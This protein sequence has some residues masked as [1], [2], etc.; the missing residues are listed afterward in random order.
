MIIP[1]GGGGKIRQWDFIITGNSLNT[2]STSFVDM[3]D[4][5]LTLTTLVNSKIYA[6]FAGTVNHN[7]V[8][9]KYIDFKLIIDGS[10]MP[11][12]GGNSHFRYE[13]SLSYSRAPATCMSI[14]NTLTASS[15]TIKVQW[16]V[17]EGA[18]GEC[19]RD[20]GSRALFIA[21]LLP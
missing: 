13:T 7:Q 17:Q 21:E 5:S 18:T 19:P 12:I 16:R 10:N 20:E 11:G 15:H 3:I 9:A 2:T 1:L 8:T 6:L 4:M 14:S